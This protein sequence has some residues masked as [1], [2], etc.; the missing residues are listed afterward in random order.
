MAVKLLDSAGSN[1]GSIDAGGAQ[2]ASIRPP[3]V[4]SNGAYRVCALS[5]LIT[6]IAA[7]TAS[8]GHIFAMRWG[9]ATKLCIV[10]KLRAK[11]TTVAGFTAAQEIGMDAYIA[12]TYTADHA[13]GTAVTLT[14][15]SC[16]KRASYGTTD[17][18]SMRHASTT[19]LTGS[20][21]TLDANPIAYGGASELATGAAVPKTSFSLDIVDDATSGHPIILA[22]NE[23]IVVRNTVLMGAGGTARVA[24]EVD[25]LEV[26]AGGY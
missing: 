21:F 9:H 22:T 19:A 1:V 18:T 6:G 23:G 5:G 20:S 11:W 3:Y 4:G 7:G 17:M 25:W 24:F 2:R 12:R 10:T 15:N 8:A 13:G 26:D 16:K 14:T